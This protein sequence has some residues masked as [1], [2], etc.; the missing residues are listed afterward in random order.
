MSKPYNHCSP[1]A[2]GAEQHT[3]ASDRQKD[4]VAKMGLLRGEK[5]SLRAFLRGLLKDK[6]LSR[7]H[8]AIRKKLKERWR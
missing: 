3:C 5:N 7:L 4:L 1:C 8:P 2:R 6:S